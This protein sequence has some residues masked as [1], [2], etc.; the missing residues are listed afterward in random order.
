MTAENGFVWFLPAYISLKLNETKNE[1]I[2]N[3][4]CSA[5]LTK[6]LN[7]HFAL[8]YA[9]FGNDEDLIPSKI[10]VSQWKKNYLEKRNKTSISPADYAPFVYDTVWVYVKTLKQLMIA[11]MKLLISFI[12]LIV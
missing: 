11:G 4:N 10:N 3:E 6:I 7:G 5:P 8:S 2:N 1:I 12:Q 9:N